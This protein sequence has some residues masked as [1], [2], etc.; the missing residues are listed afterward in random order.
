MKITI[1]EDPSLLTGTL[2]AFT[3]MQNH[4]LTAQGE[5]T[6]VT[7]RVEENIPLL[8]P[9]AI[10]RYRLVANSFSDSIFQ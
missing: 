7:L 10:L 1:E 2:G 3:S 8:V 9:V 4:T 5:V 6:Q